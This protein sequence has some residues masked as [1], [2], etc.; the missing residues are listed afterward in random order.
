M[1]LRTASR[2]QYLAADGFLRTRDNPV[3]ADLLPTPD[4]SNPAVSSIRFVENRHGLVL[5]QLDNVLSSQ[6]CE[7]IVGLNDPSSFVS[8]KGRYEESK[9]RGSRLL[10]IDE[11][12][13][14]LIWDRIQNIITTTVDQAGLSTTPLGFGVSTG[15][16]SLDGTNAALRINLFTEKDGLFAPHVDAQYCPHADRRSLLSVVVYLTDDFDGGETKFYFPKDPTTLENVSSLKGLTVDEEMQHLGGL[17]NGYDCVSVKPRR[18]SAV[19]FSQNLLHEG[20]PLTPKVANDGVNPLRAILRMDVMVRREKEWK[21][22][23]ISEAE[24]EDY[25]ACLTYFREAQ[26]QELKGNAAKAGE[27]YERSLSIRYSYPKVLALSKNVK[28]LPCRLNRLPSELL[29]RIGLFLKEV[30]IQKIVL[31]FPSLLWLLEAY[32][33]S[34]KNLRRTEESKD[35]SSIEWLEIP[36]WRTHYGPCSMLRFPSAEFFKN[37]IE[38]CCRVAAVIAFFRLGH[39]NDSDV[40]TVSYNPVTQ[41]AVA[42][43]MK[44]VLL[45]VFH[46]T[47]CFGAL[48]K[49]KQQDAAKR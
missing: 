24:T 2:S 17:Q 33:L 47:P 37:N 30:D 3:S 23:V 20:T 49:V 13:S 43:D 48:F 18:G 14:T 7:Q 11:K 41:E 21:G 4:D 8:M 31:A 46:Q 42:V 15:S 12:L 29:P 39:T 9:R 10:A 34:H 26:T 25:Q 19:V 40:Y 45:S 35:L 32:Q 22:F 1:T 27:L 16:W 38:G 44:D 6:E 28:K 5:M 36:E